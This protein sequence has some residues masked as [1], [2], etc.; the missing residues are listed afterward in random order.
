M[1][2]KK[3]AAVREV[4]MEFMRPHQVDDAK[5]ERPAIYITFGS[6]EWH[7]R[8]NV[9]GVDTLTAHGV[10]V[11]LAREA[12]GV[13][14]PPVFLGSGGGHGEFPYTYMVEPRACQQIVEALLRKAEKDGFTTAI[15]VAGH[16]PNPSQF[17]VPAVQAYYEQGGKMRVLVFLVSQLKEW[18]QG[19]NHGGMYETSIMLDLHPQTVD[20]TQLAG[21]DE[22]RTGPD[23]PRDWMGPE[24]REHPCWGIV[25]PDPRGNA[26]AEVG[27]RINDAFVRVL[28]RWLDGEAIDQDVR[29]SWD[30]GGPRS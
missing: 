26:S 5:A 4:R 28:H 7:G 23:V 18:P 27:R 1:A 6:T 19:A 22:D 24:H 11:R 13:V 21:H 3:A 8:Q 29:W 16:G 12:G 15:L 17:M 14:F 2:K 9:L 20:M 10:L 30:V 25:D